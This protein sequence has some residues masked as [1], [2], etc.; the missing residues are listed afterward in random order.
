MSGVRLGLKVL[1]D[2]VKLAVNRCLALQVLAMQ[3]LDQLM[4]WL[5]APVIGVMPMA[6]QE[7]AARR[8]ILPTRQQPGS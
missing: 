8:L 4:S 1:A 2:V 3:P 7:L 6:E 5:P